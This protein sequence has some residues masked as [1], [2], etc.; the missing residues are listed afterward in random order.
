M[1]EV[2]LESRPRQIRINSGASVGWRSGE[3]DEL[4]E[5]EGRA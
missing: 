3:W 4:R 1:A 5:E 2:G